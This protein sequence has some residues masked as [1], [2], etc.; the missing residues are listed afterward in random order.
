[1]NCGCDRPERWRAIAAGC[2]TARAEMIEAHVFLCRQTARRVGGSDL[3]RVDLEDLVAEGSIAL[4]RAVDRYDHGRGV[5]FHSCA[6]AYIRG[7][8]L[9]ALRRS[10]IYTR[11]QR[12]WLT[13]AAAEEERALGR[14][15]EASPERVAVALGLSLDEFE[16]V[17]RQYPAREA[18]SLD[19]VGW[20][21][22]FGEGSIALADM[23][24]SPELPVVE[25]VLLRDEVAG[26][27]RAIAALPRPMRRA[28]ELRAYDGLKVREIAARIGKSEAR[29]VQLCAEARAL[30]RAAGHGT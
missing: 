15:G 28:L 29:A 25:Q 13:R 12:A 8:V 30:L 17:N 4:I 9:E 26:L 3:R 21:D 20:R 23:I 6:I 14:Y 24:A 11:A 2:E 19:A 5:K 7:G 22:E 16:R 1:M 27:R 18:V 10:D